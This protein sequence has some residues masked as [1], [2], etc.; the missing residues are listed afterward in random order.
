MPELPEVE[1]IVKQLNKVIS[2]EKITD[3]EVL[4]YGSFIDDGRKIANINISSVGRRAKTII[5]SFE[6]KLYLL[7]HLKMTGQLIYI[8][9]GTRLAGG[10]ASHEWHEKLPS[11]HT[12]VIFSFG[13]DKKLYF[14]DLRKFGWC[15]IVDQNGYNNYFSKFGPE[16]YPSIDPKYLIER[17]KRSPKSQIKKFIMDQTVIAGVG[18]IYA[19]EALFG[20]KINPARMVSELSPKEWLSLSAKISDILAF[21][22]SKGGTTDSDYLNVF[23]EKGGMQNYL[24]VYHK[25]GQ[26]CPNQCGGAIEKIKLAGR[27]THYCPRC[28]K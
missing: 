14:N 17:S 8:N 20:S 7:I 25:E 27:G 6:N 2:G 21:S 26:M 1:T 5:I 18:N 24:N 23:G 10:H 19:D 4:N 22:I 13:K 16:A 15:R 28:Q 3:I 11:K 9:H 12:R